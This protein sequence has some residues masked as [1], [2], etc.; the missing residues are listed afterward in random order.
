M[1]RAIAWFLLSLVCSSGNDALMKY[2]SASIHP[3]QVAFYR[4]LFGTL[5][6]LPIMLYQGRTTFRTQRLSLHVLR[7]SLL[8]VAIGL[9]SHGVQAA[10]ITT[11]TLMSFTVPIFVL[12][13]A[14]I[15][16]QER[17]TWPMWVATLGGFVGIVVVVQ[18]GASSFHAAAGL[19]VLAAA[20]FGALDV[21]NKKYVSQ[22]PMLCMLFY[23]TSVATVLMA[24]PAFSTGPAAV[25]AAGAVW[26]WLL[27]LGAGS[28]L[29]LYCLLRAF[30]LANASALA[31]LRY[32]E[33][34]ISTS[35]G[36]ACF[37]E[38]PSSHSYWGAAL[39]IPCTLF[40]AKWT[41]R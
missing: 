30:A 17:V 37:G 2:A 35:I 33:L 3:W 6:L 34:L 20:L 5:T 39:I 25:P 22:E 18:P 1:S 28:N 29:I 21:I 8:F 13:L 9:W 14:P 24:L 36:Y 4:C 38:L 27:A 11:A 16:L 40:I 26:W 10:P 15:F 12:I 41:R 23:S 19:L 31:P 32:L 7:G